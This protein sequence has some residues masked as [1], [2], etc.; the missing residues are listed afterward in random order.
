MN[1]V[2]VVILAILSVSALISLFR[3]FVREALSLASWVIAFG[4]AVLFADNAAGMLGS[5]IDSPMGRWA[6]AFILIVVISLAIG[7]IV[8]H[9]AGMAIDKAGLTK[10]D[11]A[12]GAMFGVLR[13]MVIV[14]V[15]LVAANFV[16]NWIDA[17]F[18][19]LWEDS[20]IVESLKPV[21]GL[22]AALLPDKYASVV[23]F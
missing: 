9:V 23:T 16:G 1:W 8:N 20:I 3:G 12:L 11:R 19:S 10:A 18:A 15:I 17:P 14:L 4:V 2:D 5:W 7:S 22:I 21:A 6:A 13:G